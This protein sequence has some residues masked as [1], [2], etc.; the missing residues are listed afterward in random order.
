MW[1]DLENVEFEPDILCEIK[2]LDLRLVP[3]GEIRGRKRLNGLSRR[4]AQLWVFR[5]AASRT[6]LA[7]MPFDL[8]SAVKSR[9]HPQ[10]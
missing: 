2:K 4:T 5:H 9:P 8:G 7:A 3:W 10:V 6:S 1:S